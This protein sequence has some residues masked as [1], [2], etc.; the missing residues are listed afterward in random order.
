MA[1]KVLIDNF[2]LQGAYGYLYN[3]RKLNL[4]EECLASLIESCIIYDKI[5]VFQEILN[6]NRPCQKMANNFRNIISGAKIRSPE[7]L[8]RQIRGDIISKYR[9]LVK[10]DRPYEGID[11]R[12]FEEIDAIGHQ[13]DETAL[14]RYLNETNA[15]LKPE[16]KYEFQIHKDEYKNVGYQRYQYSLEERHLYYSW[17]C[18]TFARNNNMHY[19]PNPTRVNLFKNVS[20]A[21]NVI[22]QTPREKILEKLKTIQEEID[23]PIVDVLKSCYIPIDFPLVYEF[24]K[25]KGGREKI[26]EETLKIRESPEAVDFRHYCNEIDEALVQRDRPFLRKTFSELKRVTDKWKKSLTTKSTR[27]ISIAIGVP[28]LNVSTPSKIPWFDLSGVKGKPHLVFLHSLLFK[29]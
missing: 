3:R 27:P 16:H 9:R 24:V 5:V 10:E 26:V 22:F 20:F 7:I 17:Y 8:H 13:L 15:W 6:L 25:S 14:E 1:S 2:S 23:F 29:T 18:Y 19:V 28:F 12:Q 21:R 4:F 11:R